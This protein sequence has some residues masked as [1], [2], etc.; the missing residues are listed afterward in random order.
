MGVKTQKINESKKA[1][2]AKIKEQLEQTRDVLFTDFRGL[3]VDQ[4]T[5]LRNSLREQETEY[6]V[7]KNGSTRIAMSEMGL[8]D[9][10]EFL[11]GP[12][13]LALV[14]TDPG[15]VAK[16]ILD[17]ARD[18]SVQVKGGIVGGRVLTPEEVKALSELPGREQLLAMLMNTMNAPV[19][20][21]V[22]G[23]QGVLQNLVLTVKAVADKK[24]QE[25]SE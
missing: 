21:L 7:V 11:F 6:K 23:L 24:S 4:I 2:V 5:R 8:P 9:V 17:F 3:N 1:D 20:K 25:G 16:V 22:Y 18:S 19:Q 10:S 12:T 14:R 15:P 13:A